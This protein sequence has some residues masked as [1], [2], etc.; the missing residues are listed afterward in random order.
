[1]NDVHLNSAEIYGRKIQC[2]L[3]NKQYWKLNISDLLLVYLQ[4]DLARLCLVDPEDL[5]SPE[6]P[7]L[8]ADGL[9]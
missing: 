1:M 2:G 7:Y 8:P 9:K 6:I 3:I 5:V 4:A